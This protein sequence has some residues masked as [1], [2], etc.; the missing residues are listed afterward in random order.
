VHTR[1]THTHTHTHTHTQKLTWLLSRGTQCSETWDCL[2]WL[3]RAWPHYWP[4]TIKYLLT[5]CEI[6]ITQAWNSGRH[7]RALI[8]VRLQSRSMRHWTE[9]MN[10]PWNQRLWKINVVRECWSSELITLLVALMRAHTRSCTLMRDHARS[11]ALM[12]A[13][14]LEMP[15]TYGVSENLDCHQE[16]WDCFPDEVRS[17]FTFCHEHLPSHLEHALIVIYLSSLLSTWACSYRYLPFVTNTSPHT[18]SMHLS[19]FIIHHSWVLGL[20]SLFIFCYEHL[21]THLEHA[22]IIFYLLS[23]LNMHLSCL[24][25]VM[26]TFPPTHL[27][28]ALGLQPSG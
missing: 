24:S 22:L 2:Q 1:N 6:A 11:C 7:A 3:S 19:L 9:R 23:L 13:T 28:H 25:F 21:L 8:T 17:L 10:S 4:P 26:N 18:L 15:S 14:I 5:V 27:E 20:L 16:A 12:R